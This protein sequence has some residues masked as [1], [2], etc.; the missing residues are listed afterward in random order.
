MTDE[1]TTLNGHGGTHAVAAALAHGVETMFTLSGAH[2]F[3]LYDAAVGGKAGVEAGTQAMRLVDVRHE[4][5]K[6]VPQGWAE[7]LTTAG[8]NSPAVR[9]G[10]RS[11]P[12]SRRSSAPGAWPGTQPARRR[13]SMKPGTR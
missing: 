4:A 2:V 1:T 13:S 10:P 12:C 8:E 6:R 7:S 9:P 3:P 5:I 11:R